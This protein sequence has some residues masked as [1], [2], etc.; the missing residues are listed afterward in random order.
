MG[1][2]CM[3][4]V[5]ID[6]SENNELMA[7]HK[8]MNRHFYGIEKCEE[9]K[10]FTLNVNH[11]I[12]I[13]QSDSKKTKKELRMLYKQFMVYYNEFPF[14]ERSLELLIRDIKAT[15]NTYKIDTNNLEPIVAEEFI[16]FRNNI[17]RRY[18]SIPYDYMPLHDT[19]EHYRYKLSMH[20][21][22]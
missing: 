17:I 11:I 19:M 12:K 18:S 16:K 22:Y 5:I 21:S 10:L 3:K 15:G 6:T 8:Y 2:T 4:S 7:V 13:Y 1:N 14:I 9:I 20:M